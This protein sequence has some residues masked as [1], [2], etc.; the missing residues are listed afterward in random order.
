[1]DVTSRKG[2]VTM[3]TNKNRHPSSHRQQSRH[4]WYRNSAAISPWRKH[5][6]D[7]STR[8][9]CG[10]RAAAFPGDEWA[11]IT[12]DTVTAWNEIIPWTEPM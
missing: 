1:M 12:L 8:R 11:E 6:K 2:E 9:S 10:M 4:S 3:E 7:P 5:L